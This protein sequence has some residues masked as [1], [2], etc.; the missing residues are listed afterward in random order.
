MYVDL[1]SPS[2]LINYKKKG[3]IPNKPRTIIR[4]AQNCMTDVRLQNKFNVFYSSDYSDIKQFSSSS[5]RNLISHI[6]SN[7]SL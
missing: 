7:A 1:R 2:S 3:T 4:P 5:N 6:C